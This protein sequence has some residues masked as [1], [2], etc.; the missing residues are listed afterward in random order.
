MAKATRKRSKKFCYEYPR[1]AVTVDI[2][3]F[4]RFQR[5]LQVLLIKR[6]KEPFKG[7]WAFPGGFVDE[8]EALEDAA[9]RELREE[10][11]LSDIKLEQI[12]AFGDPGRDPR[13]HTISVAF[14]AVLNEPRDARAADDASDVQWHSARRP[15][16]LAFDHRKILKIALKRVM[17]SV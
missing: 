2:V 6:G 7:L 1:P 15:P 14:A 5:G 16:K 12:S 8:N 9:A 13:G 17:D 11:G 10:T 4:H 3:L